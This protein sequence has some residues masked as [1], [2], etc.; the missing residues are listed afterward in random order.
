MGQEVQESSRRRSGRILMMPLVA[1]VPKPKEEGWEKAICPGCGRQCWDRPVLVAG[2][3]PGML[4]G[5]LCT[6]CALRAAGGEG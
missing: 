2:F 1:N 3:P 4:T 6:M 5:K